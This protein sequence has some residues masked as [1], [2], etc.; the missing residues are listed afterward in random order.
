MLSAVA[1]LAR[2][3]LVLV[4]AFVVAAEC[5]LVTLRPSRLEPLAARGHRRARVALGIA[6]RLDASLSANPLGITLA[7]LALGWMGAPTFA[8]LLKP[9][10]ARFGAWAVPTAH[11]VAVIT[12]FAAITFLHTV[13]GELAPKSL[14]IQPT[15]PV[16]LWTATPL[17][18]FSLGRL[19]V[20]WTLHTAAWLVL[21]LC[22]LQRACEGER[23]HAPEE[24]RRMLPRVALASGTRRVIARLFDSPPRVA[25]HV[26][27]LRRD[28]M[29]EAVGVERC[30]F[31]P[32]GCRIR[33]GEN[34]AFVL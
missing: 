19:P 26:M 5:A 13:L 18:V 32:V 33:R 7:S 22:A 11:A 23:L 1:L 27:T 31:H 2:V 24:L 3:A 14:A 34:A 12:R 6:R 17:R 10:C 30:P 8:G 16:A 28:G 20:L 4:N 29:G 21:R 9:L 15:E 25:Q